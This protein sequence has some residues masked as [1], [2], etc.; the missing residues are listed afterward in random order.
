MSRGVGNPTRGI[1]GARSATSLFKDAIRS[2]TLSWDGGFAEQLQVADVS[3]GHGM[4]HIDAA[5]SKASV[6]AL[7]AASWALWKAATSP[8]PEPMIW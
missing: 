5:R 3:G 1:C 4:E 6:S 7:K 2:S 8:V